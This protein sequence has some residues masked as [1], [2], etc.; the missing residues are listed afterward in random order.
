LPMP[1]GKVIAIKD[2]GVYIKYEIVSGHISIFRVEKMLLQLCD[3]F[4]MFCR[5]HNRI[6]AR[7]SLFERFQFLPSTH[8]FPHLRKGVV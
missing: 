3:C 7:S 6:D 5:T 4:F 2:G 1:M 8:R